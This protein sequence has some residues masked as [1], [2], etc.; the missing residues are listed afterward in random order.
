MRN[1]IRAGAQ[2]CASTSLLLVGV[3]MVAPSCS[4][5][6]SGP[7]RYTFVREARAATTWFEMNVHSL[8]R[9]IRSS[10]AYI[11][12][13]SV[14]Q[15]GIGYGGGRFGR[16]IV[17]RPDG[18]QIGWAAMNTLSGGLQIGVQGF[19]MLVVLQDEATLRKFQADN[20]SGNVSGIVVVG[21]DGSSGTAPFKSG[22]AVYQGG[23]RGLMAG[24]NFGLDYLRY[25]RRF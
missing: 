10:A 21:S 22:V 18:E 17:C 1:P 15:W 8:D 25:E 12:F 5:A 2:C 16:A 19:K 14:G 3:T 7:E 11:I 24:V 6:P 4:T 13:P 23:N 9:Q 20:L